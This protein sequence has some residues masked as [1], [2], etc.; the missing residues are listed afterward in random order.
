LIYVNITG[1]RAVNLS[2]AAAKAALFVRQ[3]DEE[4]LDVPE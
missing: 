2:L 3:R 4:N 1:S